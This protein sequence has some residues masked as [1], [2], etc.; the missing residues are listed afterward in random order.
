M[1]S[2]KELKEANWQKQ[3][4]PG[5]MRRARARRASF[6]EVAYTINY[7]DGKYYLGNVVDG[8]RYSA[9]IRE[10][11]D[12]VGI[13]HTHV[14][15]DFDS[16]FSEQDIFTMMSGNYKIM[17]LGIKEQGK[18]HLIF[19]ETWSFPPETKKA[20]KSLWK[21]FKEIPDSQERRKTLVLVRL[22]FLVNTLRKELII[23]NQK[24]KKK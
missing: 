1:V 13:F 4:G 24:K 20:I 9:M 7:K 16:I 15:G 12:T 3:I 14:D 2:E 23:M 19:V 5:L 10:Q 18:R 6:K 8:K 17:V 21:G 11:S 22:T